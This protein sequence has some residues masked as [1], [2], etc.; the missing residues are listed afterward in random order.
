MNVIQMYCF[1]IIISKVKFEINN[2]P[3]KKKV[4]KFEIYV[5]LI[6]FLYIFLT[7]IVMHV[8]IV[9][10]EFHNIFENRSIHKLLNS[11]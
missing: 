10:N 3:L 6:V 2:F 5:T 11:G 9:S 4:T 1:G 7:K 8:I